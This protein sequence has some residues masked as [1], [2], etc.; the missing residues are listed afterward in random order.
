MDIVID[1]VTKTSREDILLDSV[2][3]KAC[4]GSV[5]GVLGPAQAGKSLLIQTLMGIAKP[6]SGAI[7]FDEKPLNRK[8]RNRIGYLP[9]KRGIYQ[10]QKLID[11]LIYFGRLR[12]LSRKKAKIEAIRLLD[13][14]GI[15]DSMEKAVAH[16]SME[17]QEK[18][19]ILI[20]IIHNPDV[21][22]LDE[23]FRGLH[24][25]N[26]DMLRK[27]IY[28]LREEEKTIIIS[29]GQ[30][31]EAEKLCDE[32]LFLD[33]GRMILKGN[34]DKLRQK[35]HAHMVSIESDDNLASLKSIKGVKRIFIDKQSAKLFVDSDL[36]RNEIIQK[37]I[38]TI[39][40]SRIEINRPNLA[41]IFYVVIN[42][43]D[44]A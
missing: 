32:V 12:N 10:R 17:V 18:L 11:V 19:Q 42:G 31:N 24:P 37:I 1:N 16:V 26:Q 35:F 41:D 33:K 3:F 40:V 20:N 2:S 21:L 29:T 13:R 22:I 6:D 34:L 8:I 9:E 25:L 7:T 27:M 15:I 14:Y 44:A 5:F 38:S 36:P 30:F 28:R 23:P 39:N 4:R 43:K